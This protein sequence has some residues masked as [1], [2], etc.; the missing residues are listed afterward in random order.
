MPRALRTLSPERP[1][2]WLIWALGSPAACHASDG[3]QFR[4]PEASIQG[5][6]QV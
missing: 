6:R 3:A 1:A 4:G 2:T 5:K